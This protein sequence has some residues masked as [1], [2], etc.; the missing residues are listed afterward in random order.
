MT[1]LHQLLSEDHRHCDDLFATAEQAASQADWP[2]AQ[3]AFACFVQAMTAHFLAEE[4][5]LFPAFEG[6]TGM[7]GG[8]TAVMRHEHAQMREL[9]AAAQAALAAG[10]GDDFF[11]VVDTLLIMMQQHNM[12]EENVLYPMCDQHLAAQ[13]DPLISALQQS[14]ARL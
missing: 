6:A 5:Q 1:R 7:T 8:P 9:L 13:I 11:A 3:A 4:S 2:S 12:K 14:L 10:Q